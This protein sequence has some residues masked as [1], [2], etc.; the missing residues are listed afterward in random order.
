MFGNSIVTKLFTHCS[1]YFAIECGTMV[2]K[3][4]DLS[5]AYGRSYLLEEQQ[6]CL[7]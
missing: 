4:K 5:A 3:E 1:F 7:K 2:R 6:T